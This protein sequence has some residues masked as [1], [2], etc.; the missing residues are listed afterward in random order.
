M[1]TLLLILFVCALPLSLLA[2]QGATGIEGLQFAGPARIAVGSDNNFLVDRTDP[3][4]KLFI[5]SLPP[6]VQPGAPNILPEKL[7]DKIFTFTLP[8]IAYRNNSRRHEFLTTWV[9]EFEVFKNNG[10]Q[11][12]MSTDAMASFSYYL[13]RNIQVWIG[14]TYQS[15]KDPARSLENVFLLLPRTRFH[16]NVLHGS[17]DFQLN[18]VTNVSVGYDNSYT[19]FGDDDP[20]Q[21][22]ILDTRSAGYTLGVARLLSRRSR[23]GVQY[24][25]FKIKPINR[26]ATNDDVVDR[27]RPFERPIHSLSLQYWMQPNPNTYWDLSGGIIKLDTGSEYTVS[28]GLNRRLGN[29]WAGASY[30]RGLTFDTGATNGFAQGVNSY[31]FY[32]VVVLRFRGQPSPRTAVLF[33]TTLSR[34]VGSWHAGSSKSLMGRLRLDYRATERNTLFATWESFA[35]NRN[36]YVQSPLTR[37]RFMIGVEISLA[38]ES[39]RRVSRLNEE[40]QFIALTNHGLRR[41]SLEED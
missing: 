37:N 11:N 2:Q 33:D 13:R 22:R 7:D 16:E 27:P 5:L 19:K 23:I 8:K 21:T 14:D 6:S 40:D 29:F 32:D 35:Q 28:A 26:V 4:E 34:G 20:F 39:Q 10:D 41:R 36:V 17:L 30:M 18:P 25:L 3:N 1:R 24:S 15:S 12:A 31:G 9:S 38:S